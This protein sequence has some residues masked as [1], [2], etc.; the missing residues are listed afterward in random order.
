M[1]PL[2]LRVVLALPD[3]TGHVGW[4]GD[5][6]HLFSIGAALAAPRTHPLPDMIKQDNNGTIFVVRDIEIPSVAG[7]A[8]HT[9][10]ATRARSAAGP[11]LLNPRGDTAHR[12]KRRRRTH[13][14]GPP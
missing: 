9:A 4:D 11:T 7:G 8:E 2:A 1:L 12:P 3:T 10:P 5:M 6:C 14:Q 13:H